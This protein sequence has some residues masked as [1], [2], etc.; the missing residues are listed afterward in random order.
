M[1]KGLTCS[2]FI[3]ENVIKYANTFESQQVELGYM[4]L[5]SRR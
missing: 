4:T 3:C 1:S 5:E 2:W